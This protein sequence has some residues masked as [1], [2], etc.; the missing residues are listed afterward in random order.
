MTLSSLRP[1]RKPLRTLRLK[2]RFN[3][4]EIRKGRKELEKHPLNFDTP[5][6]P[7]DMTGLLEIRQ[8]KWYP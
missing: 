4:K 1:L 2:R 3:R 5:S 6:Q 8:H 7:A